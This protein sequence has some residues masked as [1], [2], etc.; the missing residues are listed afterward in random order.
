L[1]VVLAVFAPVWIRILFGPKYVQESAAILRILVLTIPAAGVS[2]FM[3]LWL[4]TLHREQSLVRIAVV[5]GVLN[6]ALGSI[7]SSLMGPQGMAWSVVTVQFVAAGGTLLAVSRIRDPRIA[8]FVRRRAGSEA[9]VTWP[10]VPAGAVSAEPSAEDE[11]RVEY[12]LWRVRVLV[13]GVMGL[14]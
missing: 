8:L 14:V 10:V 3:S 9:P 1:A 4:M 7:L 6:V 11:A 5:A 2:Y 12:G 13:G